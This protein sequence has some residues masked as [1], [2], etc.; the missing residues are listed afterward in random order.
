[1]RVLAMKSP[2]V[3]AVRT[4]LFVLVSERPIWAHVRFLCRLSLY[5]LFSNAMLHEDCESLT[6]LLLPAK[7]PVRAERRGSDSSKKGFRQVPVDLLAS[8]Q[9]ILSLK[10]MTL[11]TSSLQGESGCG[12]GK[13]GAGF[14]GP[15][16]HSTKSKSGAECV[17]GTRR[18]ERPFA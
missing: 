13:L 14:P 12:A 1:M 6:K 10:P 7:T 17:A 9:Q 8:L 5:R 2:V 18:V 4:C 11:R 16:A 3:L 15:V